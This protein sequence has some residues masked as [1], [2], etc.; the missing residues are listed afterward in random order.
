MPCGL[1][2]LLIWVSLQA[3]QRALSLLSAP[4]GASTPKPSHSFSV[5]TCMN[6]CITNLYTTSIPFHLPGDPSL[7]KGQT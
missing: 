5:H 6:L 1:D 2:D 3:I 7:A 4:A